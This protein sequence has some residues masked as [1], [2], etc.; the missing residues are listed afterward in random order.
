MI[1]PKFHKAK[2]R[3]ITSAQRVAGAYLLSKYGTAHLS[4]EPKVELTATEGPTSS[5]FVFSG[6]ITCFAADSLLNQVGVNM[7]VNENDI[8]VTS[9]DIQ[10]NIT[11][12]V[13]AAKDQPEHVVASLDGFKLTDDGT[14]Y[15]KV[16]HSDL[17]DANLGLVGKNEYA[18]SPNRAELLQN[19][20]KDAM[21][22]L[23][24]TFT[25]EFK[26]PVIAKK[27][28]PTCKGKEHEYRG[29][30][31]DCGAYSGPSKDYSQEKEASIPAKKSSWLTADLEVPTIDENGNVILAEIDETKEVAKLA[32]KEDLPMARAHDS[33]AHMAQFQEQSDLEAQLKVEHEAANSLLSLLQGMGYG[34]AKAV[35]ITSSKEGYDI[36]TAIDDAGTVKAVSIPVTVKEGKV[37]L[38]KKA[39]VSTLIAKGLDAKA[40]L[41]EQFDLEALEKL[42]A[43][44]EKMAYE[45]AEAD[46]IIAE[47]PVQKEAAGEKQP[48]FDSDDSTMTVQKHLLP[49]HEDL[50]VGDRLNDGVDDWEIVNEEGQQ[51]DKNEGS[52]SQWTLKKVQGP[53]R[54]GKK[55]KNRIPS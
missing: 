19:I 38:P 15:L 22:D 52:S 48:F 3:L 45:A 49:N 43:I 34:T 54:D 8:E 31:P 40:K 51:N 39:L 28:C 10:A 21:L 24:V 53:E 33:M 1:N 32:I 20:V 35:E 27:E 42:A 50:K 9:E 37:V 7:T 44:D 47:R 36:M 30:C 14:V 11:D 13:N 29:G 16:S 26:E 5:S 12:A 18:M 23:P 46:A 17:Q 4:G 2:E 25:G 6:T 41:M 55:V